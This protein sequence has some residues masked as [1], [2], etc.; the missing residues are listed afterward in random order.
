MDEDQ[1]HLN[2]LATFHYVVAAILALVSC[3][4][5]LHVG[6]GVAMLVNP[7]FM[8]DNDGTPPPSWLGYL[9]VIAGAVAILSGWT[10]AACTILSGRYIAKR[11]RRIFSL[12][13]AA[14][15]CFFMP[16]GTVLGIFTIIVLCR[17]SVLRL[18]QAASDT[19]RKPSDGFNWP[20][21]QESR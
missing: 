14:I 7:E 1:K 16:F 10:M 5:F 8:T 19:R 3:I 6:I 15:L 9:F 4:F 18:Y 12:V 21:W 13:V 20:A 2:L 11:R 17:D